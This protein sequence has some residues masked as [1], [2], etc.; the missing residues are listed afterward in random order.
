MRAAQHKIINLLKTFFFFSLVF[1][2]VCVFNVWPKTTLLL[3][4]WPRD[5]KSLDTPAEVSPHERH[6]VVSFLFILAVSFV[7]TF[8]RATDYLCAFSENSRFK[9]FARFYGFYLTEL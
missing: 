9:S 4:M 3:P 2:S 8:S 1:V 5:T 7:S 6:V